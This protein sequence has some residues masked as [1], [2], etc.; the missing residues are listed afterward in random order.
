MNA[1]TN[2]CSG[3]WTQEQI[4]QVLEAQN[5]QAM[6][7][8]VRHGRKEAYLEAAK[9]ARELGAQK[10]PWESIEQFANKLADHF[11]GLA[12]LWGEK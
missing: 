5:R 4:R 12:D 2:R 11:E 9:I 8:R 6:L 10:M 7:H 3:P 1:P